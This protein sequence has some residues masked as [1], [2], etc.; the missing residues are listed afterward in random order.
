MAIRRDERLAHSATSPFHAGEQHVQTKLGVR[1]E[2]EPWA[3]RIVRPFLPD[4]HRA[5]YAQLP[6]LVLAARD[7]AGRPWATLVSGEPGVASS[8]DPRTLEIAALP[9]SGDALAGALACGSDV[10]ILGIELD[11][12]RRNRVNGRVSERGGGGLA[13]SVEQSFGNCPQ[14]ITER[15]WKRASA[16]GEETAV[17]RTP[18]LSD[19]HR[20]LIEQADTFFIATGFRAKGENAAFGMDAS[21]RGGTPGF[22]AV[23]NPTELV[24]PD[25]AGNNHFNTLGNLT[26]DPRAGLLFVDF[27]RGD[28][29]QLTGRTRI[30]W[31]SDRLRQHPGARRLIHLEIDQ[32]V[33]LEHS[34]PIRFETA[35]A[36]VR[37]LRLVAKQAESADVA[38]FVFSARD[39]GALPAHRPG[40][41]L[42]IELRVPGHESRVQRTYSLSN[43]S[44]E[45]LY[46]ITVKRHHLGTASRI[47]HDRLAVG[48][49]VSATAPKGS[50]TL[51][52]SSDRPVALVSAGVGLTPLVSML[53]ALVRRGSDRPVWFVHGARDGD[54]HALRE[55]V[56]RLAR[57]APSVN[58]HAVYSQPRAGDLRG[59]DY[60]SA[61]HVDGGLLE[62]LIPNL[63]AEFY[64][65]GPLG[66]MA[67]IESQLEAR[68]VPANR[69]HTETFGPAAK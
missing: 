23:S 38:S 39:G 2:I 58:V 10:G 17:T 63:E 31:E 3:Q 18:S 13:L 41:H 35:G 52:E 30:D 15:R 56:E 26:M 47:L 6:F 5:F 16:G 62:T 37:E 68:G 28:L 7:S 53:H 19:R 29:L 46:R 36:A 33:W 51:D 48:E 24:F 9:S 57:S 50:F 65:C 14:Y 20:E 11:T 1:E 61:G 64:V 25:Y 54:H 59:R 43:A 34:L 42:P 40:Q 55:E 32:V 22:V 21:H 27:E 66:F 45:S 4:E 67:A 60:Q 8:P 49:F 69:I 44:G 12:R